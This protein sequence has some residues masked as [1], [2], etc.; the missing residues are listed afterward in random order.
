MRRLLWVRCVWKG[1]WSHSACSLCW[2]QWGTP[3]VFLY[4]IFW[5]FPLLLP[6][7]SI[8]KWTS[9]TGICNLPYTIQVKHTY[10]HEHLYVN[11]LTFFGKYKQWDRYAWHELRGLLMSGSKLTRFWCGAGHTSIFVFVYVYLVQLP[12]HVSHSLGY[13][14]ELRG[15][16][17]DD[18]DELGTSPDL[19]PCCLQLKQYLQQVHCAICTPAYGIHVYMLSRSCLC[20]HASNVAEISNSW[21]RCAR[22]AYF[23]HRKSSWI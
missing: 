1:S 6:N 22:T 14:E 23:V 21:L 13:L 9:R 7:K 16:H 4:H 2:L 5:I 20:C 15:N 17:F 11:S 19:W 10:T 12:H 3:T 8:D 18:S